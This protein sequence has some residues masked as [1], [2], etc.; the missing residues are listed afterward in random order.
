MLKF[1]IFFVFWGTLVS[2]DALNNSSFVAQNIKAQIPANSTQQ[3]KQP[4][5]EISPNVVITNEEEKNIGKGEAKLLDTNK[6]QLVDEVSDEENFKYYWVLLVFSSLS[7]I[8]L[9]VF[10]S[11]R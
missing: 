1:L 6:E 3:A 2:G 8:G 10:K 7:I 11:F 4:E 5:V 9:I